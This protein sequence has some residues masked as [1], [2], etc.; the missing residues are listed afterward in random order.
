MAQYSTSSSKELYHFTRSGKAPFA[1]FV[2]II[3]VIGTLGFAGLGI[4]HQTPFFYFSG[5]MFLFTLLVGVYAPY[6]YK[7]TK[8]TLTEDGLCVASSP[9]NMLLRSYAFQIQDVH[10]VW[11]ND[12]RKVPT[13]EFYNR[14]GKSVGAFNISLLS[15]KKRD[16]F[17]AAAR[18]LNPEIQMLD[19]MKDLDHSKEIKSDRQK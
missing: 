9:I 3:G 15:K 16:T 13:I 18:S 4:F 11:K 6:I 12:P 7:N 14:E 19:R 5:G 10:K 2:L 8:L 1:G 17:F